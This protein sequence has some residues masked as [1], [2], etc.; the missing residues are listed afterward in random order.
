MKRNTV[1]QEQNN[2]G[3][4]HYWTGDFLAPHKFV[5]GLSRRDSRRAVLHG[6]SS[7]RVQGAERLRVGQGLGRREAC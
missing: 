7:V 4:R 1:A 5:T 2:R 3:P 6:G